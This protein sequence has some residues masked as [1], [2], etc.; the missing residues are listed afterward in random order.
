MREMGDM[1]SRRGSRKVRSATRGQRVSLDLTDKQDVLDLKLIEA[2][3]AI[4]RVRSKAML[5]V[6]SMIASQ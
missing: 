1:Q 2:L 6:G 4:E 5:A 3:E